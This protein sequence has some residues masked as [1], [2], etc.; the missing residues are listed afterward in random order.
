LHRF[1]YPAFYAYL[2]AGA[3]SLRFMYGAAKGEWNQVIPLTFPQYYHV[4]R[5]L[6]AVFGTLTVLVVYLVGR[7]LQGRRAGLFAAVLLGGCYLHVIHSH[8]ATFDVMVGFLVALTLLFSEL[9]RSRGDVKWYALAGLCAGLAGATKYNGAVAIIMP[10]VAHVLATPWGEW[11][12]LNGRLFVASGGFLLGFFGG[13]PFAL[14]NMPDFLTGL[15][16]VLHHYGTAQP[17]FEGTGNWRW[18]IRTL[19]SSADGPWVVAGIVGLAGITWREWKKGLFLLAFPLVYFLVLSGFVVRFERNFVPV[20]PFLAVG[21]G[22]LLDMAAAWAAG[23]FGWSRGTTNGLAALGAA[24][25]LALPLYASIGFNV[26]LNRVD[27]R[28]LAGTWVEENV[29]WGSK[30]AIEH[31]SIPFDHSAYQVQDVVRISDHDL[32]WYKEQGFGVLIISDGVWELLQRQPEVYS[33]KLKGYRELVEGSTLLSEFIP[34]PPGIVVAG[35]PTVAIYHFP[36]VRIYGIA[37]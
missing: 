33:E 19:L 32:D 21:G 1:N 37:D 20:L 30:I 13:N 31:Y 11:G 26:A 6:T 4:G 24:L 35:Y 25:L 36:P 17:G 15:A 16:T 3:Y 29:E 27:L 12:W 28:E 34:D 10:L 23:R 9:I 7:Q 5:L 18:Y 14:G 8:Y 22:W 2:Q